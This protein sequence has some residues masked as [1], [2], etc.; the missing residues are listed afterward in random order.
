MIGSRCAFLRSIESCRLKSYGDWVSRMNIFESSLLL[1]R[2]GFLQLNCGPGM[3][4]IMSGLRED[5]VWDGGISQVG[6]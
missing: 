3:H 5:R 1:L 4:T 2:F 6:I